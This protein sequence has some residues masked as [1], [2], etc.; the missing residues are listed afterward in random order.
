MERKEAIKWVKE[1]IENKNLIKHCLAVEAAMRDLARHFGEDVEKWG[2]CGLLHDIDY[3]DTKDKPMLHSQLGAQM[4]Q[5]RGVDEEICKA[6]YTHNEIHEKEPESLMA[7]AVYCVD[8]LTGLIV[9]ATL[10]LP[11]KKIEDLEVENVLNRFT[12][13]RFAAG[14]NREVIK[15]CEEYLDLSLEEFTSMVLS[16][17][18]KISDKLGL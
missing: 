9:A 4:L 11:S 7:K 14:A 1:K 8:P 17:M 12:E 10:V 5:K 15:K 18:K 6:V 2:L 16:S 3:E 13:P